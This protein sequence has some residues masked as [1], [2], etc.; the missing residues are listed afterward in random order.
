MGKLATYL[1]IILGIMFVL[2]AA[3]ITNTETNSLLTITSITNSTN[4]G[5]HDILQ[6]II[7]SKVLISIAI[8]AT[9]SVIVAGYFGGTSAALTTILSA[10]M[11]SALSL[12]AA[13]FYWIVRKVGSSCVAGAIC[14]DWVYWL[15]ATIFI[16]IAIMYV[17]A[18]F[19][20][21][22]GDH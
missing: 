15:I 17:I 6:S 21:I 9:A 14:G 16:P 5:T 20:W 22:L 19:E 2:Y 12:F 1:F 3:G 10:G 8:L 4:G 18:V 11:F 13:D 7:P